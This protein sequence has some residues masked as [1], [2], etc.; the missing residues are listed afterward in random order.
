MRLW[1]ASEQ[2]IFASRLLNF[3]TSTSYIQERI[4]ETLRIMNLFTCRNSILPIYKSQTNLILVLQPIIIISQTA[5]IISVSLQS[6]QSLP[7][8]SNQGKV[9]E[10]LLGTMRNASN[11]HLQSISTICMV[12]H[13]VERGLPE[14][15]NDKF[16]LDNG[17]F[18]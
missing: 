5:I 7:V 2:K 6:L 10:Q 16:G 13:K 8:R 9:M 14:I 15:T 4:M 18:G 11:A 12:L 1:L 3:V 17:K